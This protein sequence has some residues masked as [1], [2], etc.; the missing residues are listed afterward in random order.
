MPRFSKAGAVI[1]LPCSNTY[2]AML[3]NKKDDLSFFRTVLPPAAIMVPNI[4]LVTARPRHC[5]AHDANPT[6]ISENEWVRQFQCINWL[7]MLLALVLPIAGRAP[8]TPK[9]IE[10]TIHTALGGWNQ[11]MWST[12]FSQC[13]R[14]VPWLKWV[15]QSPAITQCITPQIPF[16]WN[17]TSHVLNV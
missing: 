1:L 4:I 14:I 12:K 13:I 3:C 6:V 8:P 2:S 11:Y 17:F 16:N 10:T 7:A 9:W 15:E 5:Y